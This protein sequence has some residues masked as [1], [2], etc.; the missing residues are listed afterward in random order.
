MAYLGIIAEQR[1]IDPFYVLYKCALI[2]KFKLVE[3]QHCCFKAADHLIFLLCSLLS[4]FISR[5]SNY[6]LCLINGVRQLIRN[7]KKNGPLISPCRK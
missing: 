2:F 3:K 5:G 1:K 4:P 7:E 6:L